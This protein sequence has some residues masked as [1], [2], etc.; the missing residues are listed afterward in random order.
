MKRHKLL[1]NTLTFSINNSD[2]TAKKYNFQSSIDDYIRDLTRIELPEGDPEIFR[3]MLEIRGFAD[4][5][6]RKI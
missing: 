3:E 1:K 4:N 2:I 5:Y 6:I